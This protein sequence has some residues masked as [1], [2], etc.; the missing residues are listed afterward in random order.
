MA[1][2]Q[3]MVWTSELR[4]E[5]VLHYI[6][7]QVENGA[8]KYQTNYYGKR[9]NRKLS[10][11]NQ[12]AQTVLMAI[13]AMAEHELRSLV[14]YKHLSKTKPWSGQVL[15][16]NTNCTASCYCCRAQYW[17]STCLKCRPVLQPWLSMDSPACC[18][19]VGPKSL[20]EAGL[21]RLEKRMF[22]PRTTLP[23]KKQP[24][25]STGALASLADLC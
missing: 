17:L 14:F 6:L 22:T 15:R 9:V 5:A 2:T 23:P 25:Q 19:V 1:Q 13:A 21:S 7:R 12:L 18:S 3:T 16:Y 4:R 24:T 8:E 11:L 20:G 10:R